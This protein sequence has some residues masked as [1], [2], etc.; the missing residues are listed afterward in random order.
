MIILYVTAQAD[1]TSGGWAALQSWLPL[2]IFFILLFGLLWFRS[3][4]PAGRLYREE[5]E[6]HLEHMRK[7]EELLERIA[8]G[9]ERDR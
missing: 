8:K 4:S 3:R 2:A 5:K 1:T 6:R 9:V 7:V